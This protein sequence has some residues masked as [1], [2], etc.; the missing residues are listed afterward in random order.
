MSFNNPQEMGH[1]ITIQD[2]GITLTN[3][4]GT[5][6]FVGPG[7]T[8]SIIGNTVTETITGSGG[9]STTVYSETPTGLV[10]GSNK[11]YTTSHTIT[12]VIGIWINAEFIYP[13]EYVVSG[14]GFTMNTALD[15]S[16]SS[17]GFLISYV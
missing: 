2:E 9:G 13:S 12:T 8:G 16:F 5:I 14:A 10:D 4:V 7:V 17:T 15:A 6:N 3:S 1:P 11:I